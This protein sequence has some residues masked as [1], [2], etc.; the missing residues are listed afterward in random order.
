MITTFYYFYPRSPCGE[1][2][3]HLENRAQDLA[4]L[5][6]LSLR[7]ATMQDIPTDLWQIISIHALL[8]ESDIPPITFYGKTHTFLSTL[9]LRRAT[10]KRRY[11]AE[12]NSISIHAL[13][14]ESDGKAPCIVPHPSR[15]LSTLSLRRATPH[16][17]LSWSKCRYFYPRSPC[18]ER[19]C[20]SIGRP[21]RLYFYPRSPCGERLSERVPLAELTSISIHALL[22]ESDD[23]KTAQRAG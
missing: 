20:T 10:H 19:H 23:N 22:A 11:R 17:S 4:F 16:P 5:S 3:K 8:A 9:S 1:R 14:A 21:K 13:L 18:G 7:R 12:S 2:L 6:T 15:F